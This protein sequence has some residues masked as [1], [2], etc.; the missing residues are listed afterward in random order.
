MT[1]SNPGAPDPWTDT[2]LGPQAVLGT[3]T[4]DSVLYTKAVASANIPI[5]VTTGEKVAEA[6]TAEQVQARARTVD[7]WDAPAV[8]APT[9]TESMADVQAGPL[10]WMV[11]Y[12]YQLVGGM[13]RHRAYSAA[14]SDPAFDVSFDADYET[15]D[16]TITVE[17]AA[18][19]GGEQA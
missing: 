8:A 6:P 1:Q 12:N 17:E 3:T 2:D 19:A 9:S 14:H 11:F 15:G 5:D 16:L 7:T 13:D 4:Y 10:R 18:D